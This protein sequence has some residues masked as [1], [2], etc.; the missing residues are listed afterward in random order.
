MQEETNPATVSPTAANAVLIMHLT[1]EL[2]TATT[3]PAGAAL[4]RA[5]GLPAPDVVVLDL[6]AVEHFSAAAVRALDEFACAC[7]ER[8]IRTRL[9][10]DRGS[11]AHRVIQLA[12]LDR[13]VPVFTSVDQAMGP[14]R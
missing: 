12:E 4:L 7:A 2:D 6:T 1:G 5:A 10:T 3:A 13:R 8:G 14:H 9:V 11:I